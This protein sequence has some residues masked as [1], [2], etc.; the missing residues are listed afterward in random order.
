MSDNHDV[1]DSALAAFRAHLDRCSEIVR[2]PMRPDVKVTIIV[3]APE[4]FPNEAMITTN[5]DLALVQDALAYVRG[6][7]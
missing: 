6:G 7:K 5:D 1:S 3:R 2:R 4:A